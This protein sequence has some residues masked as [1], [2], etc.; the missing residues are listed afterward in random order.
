MRHYVGFSQ[1]GSQL[2]ARDIMIIISIQYNHLSY[3][4]LCIAGSSYIA[5]YCYVYIT[6]YSESKH[7]GMC[8]L[9][10]YHGN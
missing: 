3:K 2:T 5:R 7:V 10:D 8:S 4:S 9:S 1:I 6:T